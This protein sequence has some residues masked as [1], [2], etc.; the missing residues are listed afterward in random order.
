MRQVNATEADLKNT[1]QI[2]TSNFALKSNLAEVDELDIHELIP[3]P[4]NLSK[5]S[6]VCKKCCC[7]KNSI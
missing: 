2:D 4:V 3:V 1:T 6:D 5:Q 7:Q